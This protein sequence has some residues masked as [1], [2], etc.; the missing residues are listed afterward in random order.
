MNKGYK[1]II[2]L[3]SVF[4]LQSCSDLLDVQSPQALDS[5][6]A[7]TGKIGVNSAVI[8]LYDYLQSTR[9][10]GRDQFAISEALA[11]NGR[12]TNKSGRFNAEFQNQPNA[13]MLNWQAC[14][15]LINQA[16]LVLNAL[17]A[18]TDMTQAEKDVTAAQCFFLRALAYFD[19]AKAYAYI[20]TYIVDA[21]NRGGVPIVLK[22]TIDQGT[23]LEGAKAPA[24]ATIAETYQQIYTDLD[25]AIAR[26]NALASPNGLSKA[27]A[28]RGAAQALYSRVALYNGDWNRVV[29]FSGLAVASN[30][31]RLSANGSYVTDW[32]QQVHPEAIFDLSYQQITESIG[33]NESLQTAYT[34][35]ATPGNRSITQGFGDLVPTASML[36]ALGVSLSGTTVTRTAD[37]RGLLYELGTTGRGTAEVECTKFIGKNGFPNQDNTPIF[38]VSEMHLNRAEAY[39]RLSRRDSAIIDLNVI[40]TRAGLAA[41]ADTSAAVVG[42]NLLEEILAQRRIELAFEGHR[43]FDLKRLGRTLVKTPAIPATDY[44]ILAPIPAREISANP[45]LRQNFG[46]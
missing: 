34:T 22:G 23:A 13:H 41:V 28:N 30:L 42:N 24:R 19:L 33:P 46:Y 37:V 17:P 26:Y 15:F 27:F 8:G 3:L 31:G 10:Y 40:R 12:A 2:L 38:R 29:S 39:F 14:Y 5:Q 45:N 7:L 32:R 21:Q 25:S 4:A 43:F 18:V 44:R 36:G 11:D 35:L 1:L 20:P 9:M 16:N 6:K